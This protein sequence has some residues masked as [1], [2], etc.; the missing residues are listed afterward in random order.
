MGAHGGR[1]VPG[2]LRLRDPRG[3]TRARQPSLLRA[4]CWL[5]SFH[6]YVHSIHNYVQLISTSWVHS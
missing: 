3:P 6:R 2:E 5:I 4:P 1:E